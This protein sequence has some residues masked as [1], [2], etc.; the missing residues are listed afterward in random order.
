[1]KRRKRK[2]KVRVRKRTKK[3]GEAQVEAKV[4]RKSTVAHLV[5]RKILNP[6]ERNLTLIPAQDQDPRQ[7]MSEGKDV[8]GL[9]VM[10]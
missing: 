5:S 3:T 2:R 4:Q 1:M 6:I 8:P 10:R 7:R 9:E